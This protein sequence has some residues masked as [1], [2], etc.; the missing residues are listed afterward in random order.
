[1]SNY[2]F[3]L[4]RTISGCNVSG[5]LQGG[6]SE[7]R[8]VRGEGR[9]GEERRGEMR[10][11]GK[12]KQ[13]ELRNS[14][15][16]IEQLRFW[17]DSDNLGLQRQ[18]YATKWEEE[19]ERKAR[20]GKWEESERRKER[21]EEESENS[22]NF[23]TLI[24]ELSNYTFVLIP[25]I[26]GC[27]VSGTL[28]GGESEWSKRREESERRKVRGKWEE[29]RERR[30]GKW[31]QLELRNS[32]PE[33]SNYAFG[34]I[35]TISGCNVESERRKVRGKREE[36]IER[37]WEERR[38]VR[39]KWEVVRGGKW[40]DE[41]ERTARGKREEN[42]TK[43]RGKREENERKTRGKREENE[44]KTRGKRE[45]NERKTRGKREENE[46]KT[47]EESEG[48]GNGATYLRVLYFLFFQQQLIAHLSIVTATERA[49][50]MEHARAMLAG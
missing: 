13:L 30:G 46:R 25:T 47:R 24:P 39:G 23:A 12:W 15:S 27:N 2:A 44:R 1:L 21:G 35:T 19:S 34:L 48:S 37:K 43:T 4:I 29:E 31:K 49:T 17:S 14:Y 50:R 3:G 10:R 33:L 18:R 8:K 28:Q 22:L 11:G 7:R 36:E 26:S 5:T 38:K 40:E 41:S 20:G 32:F 42:E 45:E 9:R 16:G 6:E